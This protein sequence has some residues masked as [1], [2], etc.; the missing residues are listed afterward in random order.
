MKRASKETWC[1]ATDPYGITR[2]MLVKLF[3]HGGKFSGKPTQ[4]LPSKRTATEVHVRC[5]SEADAQAR[6]VETLRTLLMGR[7]AW[8]EHALA[9]SGSD[10]EEYIR[11]AGAVERTMESLR[12]AGVDP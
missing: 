5:S 12:L 1:V 7:L 8:K 3:R 9:T 6:L 10:S 2:A 11:A 4:W